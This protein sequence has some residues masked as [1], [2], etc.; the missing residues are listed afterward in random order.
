MLPQ[1]QHEPH[2]DGFC[3]SEIGQ[4]V[5]QLLRRVHIYVLD[6]TSENKHVKESGASSVLINGVSLLAIF[7]FLHLL[8]NAFREELAEKE[9]Y[10][11]L[12]SG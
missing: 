6:Y 8:K 11:L 5:V 7:C 12:R 1:P 10:C 4:C 2:L 3:S 9:M